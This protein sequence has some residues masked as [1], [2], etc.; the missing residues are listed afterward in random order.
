[1]LQGQ[2]GRMRLENICVSKNGSYHGLL[3]VS[4][5]VEAVTLLNLKLAK[6]AN[7][8]TGLPGNESIRREIQKRLDSG[9]AFDI[10]Y[11]DIDHFKP[12]ND[13]YGFER[14]DLV[15]S[16]VGE[17]LKRIENNDSF[18]GHIGGDDFIIIA[19]SGG[20][21]SLSKRLIEEFETDLPVLHGEEDFNRKEYS[22]INRK[23][24]A[25][26]FCLLSLSV[27]IINTQ[28]LHVSSYPQLASMA[29][30]IKKMAKKLKGSSIVIKDFEG[31]RQIP[32][33]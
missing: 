11:I 2:F 31:A 22:A 20:S 7:P 29:S 6:G 32:A 10:A 19:G 30:D 4:T 12:F 25:E 16:I 9:F 1:L 18:C 8:L 3:N 28:D 24:E 23:G 33:E 5:L 15:I 17:I 21:V 14:G 27:A 26:T 13:Y